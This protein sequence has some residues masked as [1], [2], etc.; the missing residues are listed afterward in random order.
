MGKEKK[1]WFN[2]RTCIFQKSKAIC[3]VKHLYQ[4]I[5]IRL[6]SAT[7]APTSKHRPETNGSKFKVSTYDPVW[8]GSV[9]NQ[10]P[11][12]RAIGD[13]R[14]CFAHDCSQQ[15]EQRLQFERIENK[16]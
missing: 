13:R 11:Y 16:L 7:K 8:S 1:S 2:D 6:I 4:Q 3:L 10:S 15:V 14:N 9:S 5:P 12:P